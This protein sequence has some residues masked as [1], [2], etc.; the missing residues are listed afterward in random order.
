MV[1]ELLFVVV[2]RI[3]DL[4]TPTGTL[5]ESGFAGFVGGCRASGLLRNTSVGLTTSHFVESK[6]H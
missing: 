4:L 3:H 5:F 6:A 2:D 1:P